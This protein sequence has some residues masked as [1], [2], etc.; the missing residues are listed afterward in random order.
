MLPRFRDRVALIFKHRKRPSPGTQGSKGEGSDRPSLQGYELV[1]LLGEG[2]YSRVWLG[3]DG[4]GRYVA[5]KVSKPLS[6]GFPKRREMMIVA[7]EVRRALEVSYARLL[8]R[9]PL[10][11]SDNV[12]KVFDINMRPILRFLSGVEPY[13]EAEEYLRD[14][15]YIVMEYVRG[16]SVTD[17]RRVVLASPKMLLCTVRSIVGAVKFVT[18]VLSERVHGDVKPDNIL[19]RSSAPHPMPVLTDFGTSV[20]ITWS[21]WLYGTPEYMPPEGL[22]YPASRAVASGYDAYSI[23]LT[24]Y[25]LITG[26][27]PSTQSLLIAVS[28]HPLLDP[29]R[30]SP[31]IVRL[32]RSYN[33]PPGQLITL[34][35]RVIYGGQPPGPN[36][37]V[38]RL[39]S[40]EK[41]LEEG[42]LR[43]LRVHDLRVLGEAADR[44]RQPR[45][46]VGL[47]KS[48]VRASPA[49]RPGLGELLRHIDEILLLY[50]IKC[51]D[52]R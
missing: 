21:G 8:R 50:G 15:P 46:I 3:R 17:N 49:R 16:G 44:A 20:N 34:A 14:P 13:K 26:E 24:V 23:G 28:R 5:V 4:K 19:I 7:E 43:G 33:I 45:E 27:V 36:E 18:D 41:E 6:G 37:V 25:E 47:V 48:L 29:D 42:S 32:S 1:K 11:F 9:A 40:L 39:E 12:V 35:E 30:R 10:E 22:L 38:E 51:G 52:K 31:H 2:A